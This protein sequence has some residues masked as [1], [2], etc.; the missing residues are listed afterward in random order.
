ML[1]LPLS[2]EDGNENYRS[3]YTTSLAKTRP[4]LAIAMLLAD[5]AM[6]LS[7]AAITIDEFCLKN[8]HVAIRSFYLFTRLQFCYRSLI[9]NILYLFIHE[10]T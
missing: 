5:I 4:T 3:C 6:L 9:K 2:E 7:H 1:H 10:Y 8:H